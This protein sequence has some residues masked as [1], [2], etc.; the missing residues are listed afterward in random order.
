MPLSSWM[1]I[2]RDELNTKTLILI[3]TYYCIICIVLSLLWPLMLLFLI[4]LGCFLIGAKVYNIAKVEFTPTIHTRSVRDFQLDFNESDASEEFLPIDLYDSNQ[5]RMMPLEHDPVEFSEPFYMYINSM[6]RDLHH[7]LGGMR[8]YEGLDSTYSSEINTNNSNQY[9][10]PVICVDYKSRSV[11]KLNDK[12]LCPICL[13]EVC[14]QTQDAGVLSSSL[15]TGE[16]KDACVTICDHVLHYGCLWEWMKRRETCP[17]CRREQQ[18]SQCSLLRVHATNTELV[19]KASPNAISNFG[20]NSS[21]CT[22]VLGASNLEEHSRDG[23]QEVTAV[24]FYQLGCEY[25][26][27]HSTETT[28]NGSQAWSH[29]NITHHRNLI[30]TDGATGTDDDTSTNSSI[31]IDGATSTDSSISINDPISTDGS[32]SI[33]WGTSADSS[34][35]I[36]CMGTSSD[37]STNIDCMGTSS[38]G[39]T[40]TE[41]PNTSPSIQNAIEYINQWVTYDS[42]WDTTG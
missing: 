32:I 31:N 41:N 33:D 23:S 13:N 2:E 26:S 35:S 28:R 30:N 9:Q 27:D 17:I 38:D 18:I 42:N 24:T 3:R 12:R 7:A 40:G 8:I 10:L 36:D 4:A 22:I 34:T 14:C 20:S 21:D 39:P 5:P 25:E 29:V 11:Y 19:Y 37:G 15:D 6:R 1:N 16:D